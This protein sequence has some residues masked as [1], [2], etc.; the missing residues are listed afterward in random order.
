MKSVNTSTTNGTQ[1]GAALILDGDHME[2]GL[3]SHVQ[4]ARDAVRNFLLGRRK[5]RKYAG[6]ENAIEENRN[7]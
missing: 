6:H 1:W 3:R 2:H 5:C 4:A 7:L